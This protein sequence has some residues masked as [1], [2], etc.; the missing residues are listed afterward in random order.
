M[1][2]GVDGDDLRAGVGGELGV[3]A[4]VGAHIKNVRGAGSLD[5]N[6]R[7]G[8]TVSASRVSLP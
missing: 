8:G 4:R 5:G 6:E 2:V 3:D 7:S 1:E